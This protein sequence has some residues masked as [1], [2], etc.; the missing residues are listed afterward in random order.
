MHNHFEMLYSGILYL[1]TNKLPLI[2]P[3]LKLEI[4]PEEGTFLLFSG[5]LKHGTY[6]NKFT[7]NQ[8]TP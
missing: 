3:D 5:L 2:F 7:L 6:R 4:E 8:S 1:S